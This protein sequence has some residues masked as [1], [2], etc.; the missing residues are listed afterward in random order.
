MSLLFLIAASLAAPAVDTT[1]ASPPANE[2]LSAPISYEEYSQQMAPSS[3]I[4]TPQDSNVAKRDWAGQV[5]STT[6][7]NFALMMQYATAAYCP[8]T[9]NTKTW[10]C[11][12]RC[13]GSTANTV[14]TASHENYLTGAAGYVGYNDDH[15]S[16]IVAVR[17]TAN[18][19]SAVQD[20]QLWQTP[21]DMG[22]FTNSKA[23]S[24]ALIH[25]GFKNTYLDLQ[26]TIQ[27]ALSALVARYPSYNILFSGHS[28]GGAVVSL[29]AM[30]TYNNL[31]YT[32]GEPR[33]GNLDF[34]NYIDSLPFAS[35]IFRVAKSGDLVPH[36]PPENFFGFTHH[37]DNYEITRFGTATNYCV[38]T[39]PGG[40]S[41]SCGS[42]LVLLNVVDHITGYYGWYTYPWVC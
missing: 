27:S 34:A 2:N 33:V 21:A 31:V 19:Q 1:W 12:V 36:I 3:H 24:S 32:F 23:P 17:G 5:D 9:T 28:L 18:I 30:D 11:G 37:V 29:A 6:A 13:G 39:G 16:I 42:D 7:A 26:P 41:N 10:N 25:Q 15:Q 38:T 40:E 22:G 20:I 8:S 4:F 35:R 14:I